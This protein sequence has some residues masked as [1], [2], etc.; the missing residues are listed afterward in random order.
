MKQII[1]QQT[2]KAPHPG[3]VSRKIVLTTMIGMIGMTGLP[4]TPAVSAD[5]SARNKAQPPAK[6]ATGST[7][8]SRPVLL[9]GEV[10]SQNSQAIFV[11]PSNSSPVILRNFVA[12]GSKVK[13]GDLVLRIETPEASSIEQQEASLQQLRSKT[14]SEVAKLE[15]AALDAQK[16]LLT[17]Q[18]ALSK[19]QIDA[20]LP[21]AQISALE[22]DKF[23]AEKDRAERDLKVKQLNAS[24]ADAAV[25]RSKSDG[26]LSI[27]KQQV[28]ITY[29]KTQLTRSEVR[30][31]QDGVVVHGYSLWRGERMEEG[32]SAFP[33]NVAG[34]IMSPGP[35][36]VTA[37][38]LEADRIYLSE[39][40]AVKLTFDALPGTEIVSKIS[41]ISNAPEERSKWGYGR[42]FRV[43]IKLPEQQIN[44]S[45]V[46]GM[47][48]LIEPVTSQATQAKLVP[49]V[50]TS[51]TRPGA[52]AT[53]SA[54][55]R[56]ST[57]NKN[58]KDSKDGDDITI[59][60][61]IQSRSITT[62]SPPAIPYVWQYTLAQMAAEGSLVK[63]GDVL[64][65]FQAAEVPTQLATQKSQ[66]NEKQR[67]MEK[68]KLE[69]AEAEKAAD[70]AVAEAQS[71]AEKA[72]RKATMPK[73]LIRRVEYDKLIVEKALNAELATLA[74]QLRATQARARIAEKNSLLSEMAQ[75]QGKIEVL[76]KGQQA[77]TI[78][79]DRPGMMIYRSNFNGEKFAAG[80][81]IWM[82]L[83]VASIADHEK[84][85]VTAKVPEAQS[86]SIKPGQLA[87]ITI[88]GANL[89]VPARVS[90]LSNV[91]HSKSSSQP[92]IVRDI[93][94]EFEQ[95]PKGLK[96]GAAVQA[97]L[98]NPDSAKKVKS[99]TS[100][101][102]KS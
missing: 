82:G 17:A 63:K 62:L 32:S 51:A 37:W 54:T 53:S 48:V 7:Q 68:L 4:L 60:G 6:P 8:K 41:T 39:G 80:S 3:K 20:A 26:E 92:I 42:Y 50:F 99:D 1:K 67:A 16:N 74:L 23:Q 45:L 81:Q 24:D 15:V 88:P 2:I 18:A 78:V 58:G 56:A 5:N 96:P 10:S 27:Q 97:I 93:E 59:E 66:L 57:D 25:K 55:A 28:N 95:P 34:Q 40:Q 65:T 14:E 87:R 102:R 61:E 35:K 38:A 9:T 19:A 70:L 13:K 94:L 90:S 30:A 76:Q 98:L 79:A 31:N 72:A 64:V 75:L 46:S 33:G 73:E 89:T 43:D 49:V 71:N 86:A 11:P 85:F 12:E 101:E 84:L 44:T 47:S 69:Q 91:F 100:G 83:S 52:S 29:L 77:L 36:S 21:K 22:Y